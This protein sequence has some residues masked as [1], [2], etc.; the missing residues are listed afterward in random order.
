MYFDDF[1]KEPWLAVRLVPGEELAAI[2]EVQYTGD[3]PIREERMHRHLELYKLKGRFRDKASGEMARNRR[4][5]CRKLAR[6]GEDGLRMD[7]E[8]KRISEEEMDMNSWR[9]AL[10][11]A[12]EENM[13]ILIQWL[14]AEDTARLSAVEAV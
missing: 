4:N 3:D 14:R 13:D 5:W 1:S 8:D 7:I 6:S 2:Y 10:Y 11:R 9:A 12:L